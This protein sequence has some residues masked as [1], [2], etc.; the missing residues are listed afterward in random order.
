MMGIAFIIVIITA[1]GKDSLLEVG[2]KLIL[3]TFIQN[4]AGYLLGY[5]SAR[6]FKLREKDC[7]TISLEIGMQNAGL[8]SGVAL[9]MGKLA[10]VS[11]AP[12]IFGPMMNITGSTLAT[13]WHRKPPKDK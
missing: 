8:A 6:Q 11:L 3:V 2:L 9:T 1:A 12:A 10:T 7:P 5:W 13:W 4:V